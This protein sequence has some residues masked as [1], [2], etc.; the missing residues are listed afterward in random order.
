MRNQSV[1]AA[2]A[3][4]MLVAGVAS[5]QPPKA[6][7]PVEPDVAGTDPEHQTGI[8]KPKVGEPKA[9]TTVNFALGSAV[10]TARAMG[11]LEETAGNLAKTDGPVLVAGHTDGLGE[12]KYNMELSSKRAAAVKQYL[13]AH[14]VPA[15]RLTAV[16]YGKSQ[17]VDSND[18]EEGRAHNRRVDVKPGV[19]P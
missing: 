3:L 18:S 1:L 6:K 14:G 19:N 16:G 17:P 10:L 13:V 7:A 12:A 8:E 9:V 15:E 2:V 4:S 5:A 11:F